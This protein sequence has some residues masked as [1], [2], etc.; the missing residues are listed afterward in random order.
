MDRWVTASRGDGHRPAERVDARHG[1]GVQAGNNNVQNNYFGRQR[2]V[3]WPYRVGA[4]PRLAVQRQPRPADDLLAAAVAVGG[5]A[6]VCQVLAGMGGVGKTQLAAG[7]AERL[8]QAKAVDLLV[9]VSAGSRDG[10]LSVYAQTVWM[11]PTGSPRTWAICR[12]RWR[13]LPRMCVIWT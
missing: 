1:R 4:V 12:W 11:R 10:V 7:L 6:V 2:V 9:W 3:D 13:R 5:T 8:W